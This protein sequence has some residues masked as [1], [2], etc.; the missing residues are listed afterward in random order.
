MIDFVDMK[1]KTCIFGYGGVKISI[2]GQVILFEG[3]TPPMGAGAE[4]LDKNGVTTV[5]VGNWEFTGSKLMIVFDSLSDIQNISEN[6]DKIEKAQG[7]SFEFKDITLDFNVYKQESMDV[8]KSAVKWAKYNI[9]SLM[10]V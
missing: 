3:I 8:V 4:I 2:P 5:K 6:L 10:A 9:I 1:S 7:G